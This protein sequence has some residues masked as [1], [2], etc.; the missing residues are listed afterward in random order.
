MPCDDNHRV[1]IVHVVALPQSGS[2]L[3]LFAAIV[4]V[5]LEVA[6]DGPQDYF[7]SKTHLLQLPILPIKM[8]SNTTCRRQ[9]GQS[10]H[11]S[12]CPQLPACTFPGRDNHRVPYV[13][14]GLSFVVCSEHYCDLSF[15][16]NRSWNLCSNIKLIC[17]YLSDNRRGGKCFACLD[18]N[19]PCAHAYSGCLLWS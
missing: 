10:A 3:A 5:S 17:R 1:C 9:E 4:L 13:A 2:N 19:L 14:N 7:F 6:I 15:G 8:G 11:C 12:S 18:G 16:C